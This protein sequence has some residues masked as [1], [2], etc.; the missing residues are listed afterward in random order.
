MAKTQRIQ[1]HNHDFDLD[2]L[3]H[4][5][6]AFDHPLDVA[7]D[8]DLTLNEKRAILASWASDACA[9]DSAPSLRKTTNGRMVTFDD[10]IDALRGL[11]TE[12][13]NAR[14]NPKPGFKRRLRRWRYGR[15]DGGVGLH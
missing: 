8:P 4:P 7:G 10:V 12:T 9:V 5:A 1:A 11:D 6:Q 13:Q 14:W 15:G 2:S 3:L